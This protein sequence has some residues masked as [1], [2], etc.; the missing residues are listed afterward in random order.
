M[1]GGV[2]GG[3]VLGNCSPLVAHARARAGWN[4]ALPLGPLDKTACSKLKSPALDAAAVGEVTGATASASRDR[5]RCCSSRRSDCVIADLSVGCVCGH[6][7]LECRH[8]NRLQVR[9]R[10]SLRDGAWP[11]GGGTAKPPSTAVFA[12]VPVTAVPR[13]PGLPGARSSRPG[14]DPGMDPGML[15]GGTVGSVGHSDSLGAPG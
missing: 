2:A 10:G 14:I 3:F 6:C 12:L 15:I 11:W 1:V 7:S 5:S 4:C 9:L 8:D 13:V